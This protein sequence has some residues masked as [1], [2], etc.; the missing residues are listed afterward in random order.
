M[1][2]VNRTVGIVESYTG[3]RLYS[4]ANVSSTVPPSA[5]SVRVQLPFGVLRCGSAFTV[6]PSP[7]GR[8]APERMPNLNT[9]RAARTK[10]CEPRFACSIQ[11]NTGLARVSHV[12]DDELSVGAG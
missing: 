7:F 3:V 12:I 2:S 4:V 1:L 9:N 8:E 11:A 10:K 5:F 6:P